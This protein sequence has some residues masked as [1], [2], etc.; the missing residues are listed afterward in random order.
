MVKLNTTRRQLTTKTLIEHSDEPSPH[1]KTK[2]RFFDGVFVCMC[3]CVCVCG[4]V[5]ANG[6]LNSRK[7]P[8]LILT[9]CDKSS[10]ARL[11]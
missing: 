9:T 8:W 7:A 2:H 1:V 5:Y 3:M 6:D 10:L 11:A 4:F